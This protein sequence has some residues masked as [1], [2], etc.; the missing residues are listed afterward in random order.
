MNY[1]IPTF[2]PIRAPLLNAVSSFNNSYT[3]F[4]FKQSCAKL[5]LV[6]RV[7]FSAESTYFLSYPVSLNNQKDDTIPLSTCNQ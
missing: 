2:T 6:N 7:Y 3:K 1:L 5:K 4:K